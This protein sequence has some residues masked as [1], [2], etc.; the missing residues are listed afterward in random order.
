MVTRVSRKRIV[1]GGVLLML[2]LLRYFTSYI[3]LNKIDNE[4][5]EKMLQ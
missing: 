3:K 1:T 2:L 5:V 4:T